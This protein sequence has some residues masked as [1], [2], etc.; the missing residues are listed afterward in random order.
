MNGCGLCFFFLVVD[1]LRLNRA[2]SR[3]EAEPRYHTRDH[4]AEHFLPWSAWILLKYFPALLRRRIDAKYPGVLGLLIGRTNVYDTLVETSLAKDKDITQVVILGAG[5]DTRFY[6]LSLPKDRELRLFEVDD[7]PTQTRKRQV[8]ESLPT[9]S[10]TSGR[11]PSTIDYV[12]VNF[13]RESISTVLLHNPRYNHRAKTIFLWEGVTMYLQAETIAEVLSFVKT[14]SAPGSLLITDII[15]KECTDGKKVYNM[16]K[17]AHEAALVGEPWT[18]GVPEGHV[19]EWIES[20]GFES[21]AFYGPN[22][23]AEHASSKTSYSLILP[24]I[25]EIAFVRTPAQKDA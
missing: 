17:V 1:F 6:R 3:N 15:Y 14:G 21:I 5:F 16:S 18:F 19:R 10:F 20:H 25:Q 8:L 13:D 24:D 11:A 2:A 22:E 7:V 9:P 12:S 23:L 4:L